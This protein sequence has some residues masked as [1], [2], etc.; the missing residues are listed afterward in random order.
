MEI[1]FDEFVSFLWNIFEDFLKDYWNS[2]RFDDFLSK[3]WLD[4]VESNAQWTWNKIVDKNL[5][6]RDFILIV[7]ESI[8]LLVQ[9]VSLNISNCLLYWCYLKCN[10]KNDENRIWMFMFSPLLNY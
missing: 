5:N 2:I 6:G 4:E 9:K 8:Y 7:S 10:E 3:I 1:C